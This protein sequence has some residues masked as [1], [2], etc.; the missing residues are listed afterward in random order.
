MAEES[1]KQ[2][3]DVDTSTTVNN[4]DTVFVNKDGKLVQVSIAKTVES[5][6]DKTGTKTNFAADAKTVADQIQSVDTKVDNAAPTVLKTMSGSDIISPTSYGNVIP[7]KIEGFIKQEQTTGAQ[8]IDFKNPIKGGATG[9]AT[10]RI[11]GNGKISVTGSKTT[12][13]EYIQYRV[14]ST[15]IKGKTIY[16]YCTYPRNGEDKPLLQVV[17]ESASMGGTQFKSI[18]SS[19]WTEVSIPSDM[20]G[21]LSVQLYPTTVDNTST[22]TCIFEDLKV[23]L[24][25][26]NTWEP[27]TGGKAGPNPDYP[28]EVK[29]LGVNG[30]FDGEIDIAYYTSNGEKRTSQGLDFCG[31]YPIPCKANDVIT[32]NYTITGTKNNNE[33]FRICF[34]DS[35]GSFLSAQS[36][37][38]GITNFDSSIEFT[39]PANAKSFTWCFTYAPYNRFTHLQILKNNQYAICIKSES[40]NLFNKYGQ[41][42]GSAATANIYGETIQITVSTGGNVAPGVFFYLGPI[43]QFLGKRLYIKADKMTSTHSAQGKASCRMVLRAVKSGSSV[44]SFGIYQNTRAGSWFLSS[45]IPENLDLGSVTELCLQLYVGDGSTAID[46]G[47][48]AIFEN[49]MVCWEKTDKYHPWQTGMTYIPVDQPL[50]ERDEIVRSNGEYKIIR[51]WGIEVADGSISWAKNAP[52]NTD[53]YM[54]YRSASP[55]KNT[56]GALYCDRLSRTTSSE[57]GIGVLMSSFYPNA[58]YIR[59]D[60]NYLPINDADHFNDWLKEH[61]CT[62]IY[63]LADPVEESLSPEAQTALYSIL[64]A[65]ES[66][67]FVFIDTPT[68]ADVSN[69]FLL[70]RTTDGAL[71]ITAYATSKRNEFQV[72]ELMNQTLD[73]RI[74]K[75]EVDNALIA[76]QT[77]IVE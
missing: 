20:T 69:Q 23:G 49:V 54:Y 6:I 32:F 59:L 26:F 10:Y 53:D 1:K 24:S 67:K 13:Y 21:N 58:L 46:E 3:L 66:T 73:T 47:M 43:T 4:T 71:S 40:P 42:A 68:D 38:G 15:L 7:Y 12:G 18:Q 55:M 14:S 36:P 11:L 75:L 30:F 50:F 45:E 22:A 29:G 19:Q 35:D 51:K 9:S 57:T 31:M 77:I 41:Q 39:T 63:P 25:Q 2:I 33:N 76:D 16:V 5:K 52:S 27:Y 28:L 17:Y 37:S 44:Q 61:P 60:K 74:N 62:I 48:T 34:Y 70:P 8:L 72:N 65:D 64:S 56:G